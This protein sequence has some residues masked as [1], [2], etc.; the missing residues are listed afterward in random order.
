MEDPVKLIQEWFDWWSMSNEVPVK[1]PNSLHTR[2]AV[3]L[4]EM[5]YDE[6][7]RTSEIDS[8]E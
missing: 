3:F 1:L 7:S 6:K 5:K 4:T 2:T 8:R